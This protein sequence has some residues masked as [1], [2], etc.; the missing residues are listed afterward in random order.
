MG[1]DLVGYHVMGP[2]KLDG[3][4]KKAAIRQVTEM[5]K[6]LKEFYNIHGR[7]PDSAFVKDLYKATFFTHLCSST[8][9]EELRCLD[10][11]KYPE[12]FVTEFL[13]FW[14][15]PYNDCSYRITPTG[16]MVIFAGEMSWGDEPSGS[17]YQMLKK[18]EFSGLMDLYDI[19]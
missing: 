16:L 10:E 5:K 4:K 3:R 1:A 8:L 7:D 11:I 15:S 14:K 17:G 19:T 9:L 13:S 2:M 18:A 12:K 6:V